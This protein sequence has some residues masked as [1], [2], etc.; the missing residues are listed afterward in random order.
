MPIF[1]A[2]EQERLLYVACT[3]ARDFL[4]LPEL[5]GAN[6]NSWA[7][8]INLR[9][10]DLPTIDLSRLGPSQPLGVSPDPPNLQSPELFAAQR[11]AVDDAVTPL[12]WLRPSDRD[13]DRMPIAELVAV[14]LSDTP[15]AETPVGPG[16]VR[17]LILH[18][19]MEEILTG[20]VAEEVD[21]LADRA[22]TLM[23][24]LAI[25]LADAGAMPSEDEIAA[26]AV[27]TMRLPE[28]AALRRTLIPEL[29]IYGMLDGD[30]HQ[31]A[32]AGRADAI[33]L[34]D[35]VASVVLDW[36]SDIAPTSDD[37]Q[38]HAAQLRHY[39]A[40]ISAG[41]GALVYMT[42]GTVHWIGGQ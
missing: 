30:T 18:K 1:Q 23:Q 5:S 2:R 29:P 24:E 38:A 26:T 35:G 37:I 21:Q 10:G 3:R 4:I 11:V 33:A 16:R 7:R 6:Q 8:M 32:L 25:D 22:R 15:E 39:M 41:R 14:D 31:T 20:E 17:G 13:L 36:K 12:T 19:L 40:A 42:S 9:H 27:K 34:E 28:I